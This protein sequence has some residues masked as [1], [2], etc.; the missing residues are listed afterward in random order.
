MED[1]QLVPSPRYEF[2]FDKIKTTEDVIRILKAL[3]IQFGKSYPAFEEVKDLIK[4]LK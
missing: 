1:K 3:R 4:E 2:D